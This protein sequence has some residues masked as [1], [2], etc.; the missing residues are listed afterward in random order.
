MQK[1]K[2][3]SNQMLVIRAGIHKTVVRIANREDPD[4]TASREAICT[5]CLGPFGRQLVFDILEH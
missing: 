3:E 2:G 1:K 4:Q 5:V